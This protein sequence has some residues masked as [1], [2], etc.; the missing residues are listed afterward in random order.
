MS[1][2]LFEHSLTDRAIEVAYGRAIKAQED[3]WIGFA[4]AGMRAARARDPKL[5]KAL[6][7]M[8][9]STYNLQ[10][11]QIGRFMRDP[12]STYAE[13]RGTTEHQLCREAFRLCDEGNPIENLCWIYGAA[14][15]LCGFI[16]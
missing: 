11:E 9:E 16:Y 1:D 15:W 12:S 6:E 7:R 3:G 2:L 13:S 10:E 5:L 8:A 4:Q 14:A